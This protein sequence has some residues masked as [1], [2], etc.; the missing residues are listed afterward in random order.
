MGV[1]IKDHNIL[2]SILGTPDFWQLQFNFLSR[3]SPTKIF[4][5]SGYNASQSLSFVLTHFRPCGPQSLLKRF[6][7]GSGRPVPAAIAT[8]PR[9]SAE[10]ASACCL[11]CSASG[12]RTVHLL[13]KGIVTSCSICI[14]HKSEN[15][16][17]ITQISLAD[18]RGLLGLIKL[19]RPLFCWLIGIVAPH[20]RQ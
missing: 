18:C 16:L 3:R 2:G 20:I 5:C 17:E 19:P 8:A 13:Q 4:K 9:G 12:P 7:Q 15:M 11:I 6:A 1:P 10:A 14:T